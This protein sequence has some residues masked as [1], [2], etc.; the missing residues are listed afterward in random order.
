MSLPSAFL[1]YSSVVGPQGPDDPVGPQKTSS[2]PS[3]RISFTPSSRHISRD[4]SSFGTFALP[5][6]MVTYEISNPITLVI[7]SWESVIAS[8][9]KY[10]P[11]EKLPSISKKV[12][13]DSSPISSISDVRKLFCID[14]VFF[15][16]K[17]L[18]ASVGTV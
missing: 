7:N 1:Q 8:F 3:S 13:W 9:L 18:S 6:K 14:A 17:S 15:D 5:S 12:R 11:K 16:P 4:S 10:P 2:I